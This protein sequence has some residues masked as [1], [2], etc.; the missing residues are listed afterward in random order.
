MYVWTQPVKRVVIG[1]IVFLMEKLEVIL[2]SNGMG[3][4]FLNMMIHHEKY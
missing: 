3:L 2:M 1:S 4:I